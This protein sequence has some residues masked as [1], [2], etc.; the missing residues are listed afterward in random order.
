MI[1]KPIQSFCSMTIDVPTILRGGL[2]V[3]K[4]AFDF[5]ADEYNRHLFDNATLQDLPGDD[6]GPRFII[7][8]TNLQTGSNFRFSRP[9]LADYRLEM[10]KSP[11]TPIAKAVAVSSA[12]PPLYAPVILK[13]NPTD[14]SNTKG[15]IHQD[16]KDW[17]RKLYLADRGVH[18]NLGLQAIWDRYRTVL[19]ID[20][21]APFKPIERPVFL[22]MSNSKTTLRVLD[23]AVEQNRALRKQRL[24]ND[25]IRK[26]RLGTCFGISTDIDDYKL[27]DAMTKDTPS[28]SA[29]KNF[30]TRLNKF[31]QNKQQSLINWGYALADAA[32]RKHVL[33]KN[34][35][36]GKWPK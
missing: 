35:G 15:A 18:D 17:K 13:T 6:E 3:S 5:L 20:A 11:K 29:I 26:R 7:Y 32:L 12:F 9:Y 27:S 34:P 1:A 23:I 33:K 19:V 24:I 30:R 22:K 31:D 4:S 10:L 2:S 36:P 8:G 14:W 21:G 28:T 25:F 16:H